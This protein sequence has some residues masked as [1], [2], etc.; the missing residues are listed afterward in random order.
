M[1]RSQELERRFWRKRKFLREGDSR[2]QVRGG[3]KGNNVVRRFKSGKD[4]EI[5][6]K[7]EV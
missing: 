3:N 6:R 5:R 4:W 2:I 7:Q 1:C